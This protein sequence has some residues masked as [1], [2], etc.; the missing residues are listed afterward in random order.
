[1]KDSQRKNMKEKEEDKTKK[2]KNGKKNGVKRGMPNNVF[3]PSVSHQCLFHVLPFVL[4]R[5]RGATSWASMRGISCMSWIR[6]PRRTGGSAGAM[7]RRAWFP[8]TMVRPSFRSFSLL[9]LE[10]PEE[11]ICLGGRDLIQRI[12]C[13]LIDCEISIDTLLLPSLL[14]PPSCD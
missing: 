2:K 6:P 1:M 5:P 12:P 4:D 7:A 11:R 9:W 3:F 8:L 14:H 10:S 13:S